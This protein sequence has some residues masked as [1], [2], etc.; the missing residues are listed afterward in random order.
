MSLNQ[1][2]LTVHPKTPPGIPGQ[3]PEPG[4]QRT[5]A[6]KPSFPEIVLESFEI[7]FKGQI[8]VLH[9]RFRNFLSPISRYTSPNPL[10]CMQTWFK[11]LVGVVLTF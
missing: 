8:H 4:P 6:A 11:S 10:F 9:E 2:V 7:I 5:R 3:V 1:C